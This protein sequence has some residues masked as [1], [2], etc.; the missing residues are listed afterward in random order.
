MTEYLVPGLIISMAIILL[1]VCLQGFHRA[2][3]QERTFKALLIRML[4]SRHRLI[5][6]SPAR[7]KAQRRRNLR[8]ALDSSRRLG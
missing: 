2:L 6:F 7:T 4:E 8:Q 5:E 1:L 3:R